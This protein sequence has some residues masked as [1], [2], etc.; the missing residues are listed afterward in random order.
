MRGR[1]AAFAAFAVL[2]AAVALAQGGRDGSRGRTVPPEVRAAAERGLAGLLGADAGRGLDRLGFESRAE[3]AGAVIG[4][5]FQVFTVPPDLLA[6][7]ESA[8]IS[9]VAAPST[10]WLFLVTS[11][12]TPKSIVTVDQ[13][14]GAWTAVS[15]G[16]ADMSEDLAALLARW[17]ASTFAHRFIRSYEAASEMMEVSRGGRVLGA[18]PFRSA[19]TAMRARG[20]FDPND[21]RPTG[22]VSAQIRPAAKAAMDKRREAGGGRR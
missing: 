13:I 21:L 18:V 8:D 22:E 2:A 10:Q 17:P 1:A 20:R 11:G 19:R 14:G 4:D 3:A 9:T 6:A 5:G 15:I 16:G 7:S 12:G